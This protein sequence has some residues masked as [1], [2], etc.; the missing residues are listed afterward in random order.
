MEVGEASS[1]VTSKDDLATPTPFDPLR[2]LPQLFRPRG[3]SSDFSEDGDVNGSR[4]NSVSDGSSLTTPRRFMMPDLPPIPSNTGMQQKA[5]IRTS[6]PEAEPVEME[7]G[8]EEEEMMVGEER[9]LIG[10]P[11]PSS[12]VAARNGRGL[13]TKGVTQEVED[14]G[15]FADEDDDQSTKVDVSGKG[16]STAKKPL[17]P[18]IHPLADPATAA[19]KPVEPVLSKGLAPKLMRRD[20]QVPPPLHL[21]SA[22]GS[23][24]G[25]Q[26]SHHALS[27][28]SRS[29]GG[30]GLRF[31]MPIL[32]P[33]HT[34][35]VRPVLL[36]LSST[37]RQDH[38]VEGQE[39]KSVTPISAHSHFSTSATPTLH[40][41]QTVPTGVH[42][43]RSP[44]P[45]MP[46]PQSP[47]IATPTRPTSL[48]E[49]KPAAEQGPVSRPLNPVPSKT[50]KSDMEQ[51]VFKEPTI[52]HS[53]HRSTEM[54]TQQ[55]AG[56]HSQ[57]KSAI[58]VL[59]QIKSPPPV[60]QTIPLRPFS[61][62]IERSLSVSTSS[63][64]STSRSRTPTP[65]P[66]PADER[67]KE[68]LKREQIG[69]HVPN[70]M[71]AGQVHR[72]KPVQ[73]RHM[74]SS[75]SGLS[76]SPSP[77]PHMAHQTP[78]THH[79]E[80]PV[81]PPPGDDD[82]GGEFSPER[83]VSR[84]PHG[85]KEMERVGTGG[86]VISS[87]DE[88]EGFQFD[89]EMP[90][91]RLPL[92]SYPARPTTPTFPKPL[93]LDDN[94]DAAVMTEEVATLDSGIGGSA[95]NSQELGEGEVLETLHSGVGGVCDDSTL[96]DGVI[97][98]EIVREGEDADIL[99]TVVGRESPVSD[100]DIIQSSASRHAHRNEGG[101]ASPEVSQEVLDVLGQPLSSDDSEDSDA[102]SAESE[103]GVAVSD[104]AR[105]DRRGSG[106]DVWR[107]PQVSSPPRISKTPRILISKEV[108]PILWQY[109]S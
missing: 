66:D 46:L 8:E 33:L 18:L 27:P 6:T 11:I 40:H 88:G 97:I 58:D 47:P 25:E 87:G 94:V 17:K 91:D 13:K 64:S 49:I 67:E 68:E 99:Q 9:A 77:P 81:F 86:D 23:S 52:V 50:L 26:S 106:D 22:S 79:H 1:D 75:S 7:T 30:R 84:I 39:G 60:P 102:E 24:S 108:G 19:R 89:Q 37:S 4:R 62:D 100:D 92:P 55:K 69:G 90:L 109:A 28:I 82:D 44:P 43:I 56:V 93:P 35:P 95:K 83:G 73:S 107:R 65:S 34:P 16:S 53:Q 85:E 71:G 54:H 98:S 59:S 36:S 103:V 38:A 74:S 45:G 31:P 20:S 51:D 63:S 5:L 101:V 10:T 105:D 2:G 15:V 96:S 29:P 32:S 3:F 14:E 80:R 57:Q 61:V 41:S 21:M 70:I 72:G 42:Y 76:L 12:E 48:R 104:R 78:P